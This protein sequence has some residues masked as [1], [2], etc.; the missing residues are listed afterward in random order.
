MSAVQEWTPCEGSC[1]TDAAARLFRTIADRVKAHWCNRAVADC[2]LSI[3][4]ENLDGATLTLGGEGGKT[5]KALLQ[6]GAK[7]LINTVLAAGEGGSTE[8]TISYQGASMVMR[9]TF[10]GTYDA[11]APFKAFV[12]Y[13][14]YSAK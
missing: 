4:V 2:K 12:A 5:A 6:E 11:T 1:E 14:Y 3:A 13:R 10:I 9:C 7:D 8:V